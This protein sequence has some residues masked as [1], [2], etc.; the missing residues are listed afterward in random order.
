MMI[1]WATYVYNCYFDEMPLLLWIDEYEDDSRSVEG[2][3]GILDA[4]NFI[5]R[6]II[7]WLLYEAAI[8][9][10]GI[11]LDT[12]T[13]SVTLAG[14]ELDKGYRVEVDMI[15]CQED[16]NRKGN[17]IKCL[18][19]RFKSFVYATNNSLFNG[20]KLSEDGIKQFAREFIKNLRF[21]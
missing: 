15:A 21:A 3:D 1:D 17:V 13:M 16:R 5:V 7:D 4:S 11:V 2:E 9:L 12:A 10:T 19:L 8:R 18:P 14:H 20:H 6:Q